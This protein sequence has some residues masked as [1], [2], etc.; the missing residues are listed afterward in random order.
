V[1]YLSA[2]ACS[3]PRQCVAAG[4]GQGTGGI[5]IATVN[6]GTTWNQATLPTDVTDVTA[7]PSPPPPPPV[8]GARSAPSRPASGGCGASRAWG[9]P[10]AG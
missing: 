4:Q 6:G 7:S 9:P 1:G 2:I 10:T 5:A 8:P 3:G